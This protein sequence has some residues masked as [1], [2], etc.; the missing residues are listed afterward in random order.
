MS[1]EQQKNQVQ[2]QPK[3]QTR[4]YNHKKQQKQHVYE[5][6]VN[7]RLVNQQWSNKQESKMP[8]RGKH[9]KD[10]LLEWTA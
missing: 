2:W 5:S 3:K 8:K 4:V 6:N 10:V 1:T 9:K 7:P